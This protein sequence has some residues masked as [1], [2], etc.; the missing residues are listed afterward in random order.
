MTLIIQFL[1]R[2]AVM[3][4]EGTV[5]LVTGANRGIGK[6]FAEAL[7][8][9]GASKVYAAVRD[10]STVTDPRLVPVRLDVT[11]PDRI[12]AV[13]AELD[14]VQLVVNNAGVG[15][16]GFPLDATLDAARQALETNLGLISMTQ[17]FAPVLAGNGGGAFVNVLSVVSWVANPLLTTYA[18]SKSAAWS[19]TNAARVQLGGQGTQVVGVHVG[20]VDTDLS[21]GIDRDKIPPADVATS[22]LDAL[23]AGEREAIVDERSRMVKA[24]LSDDQRALYPTI[25]QE[26]LAIAR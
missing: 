26:F 19:Y 7:L 17:A 23:E 2:E 16:I 21:A 14:D 4:I 24:G 15:T 22:A 18:A 13:A 8:E 1:E 3:Q 11:D 9:R 10:T 6:A 25:E 12:A 20:L 5:A